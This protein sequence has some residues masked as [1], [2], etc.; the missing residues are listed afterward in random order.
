MNRHQNRRLTATTRARGLRKLRRS[1]LPCDAQLALR[2]GP[3]KGGACCARNRAT[4]AYAPDAAFV[5]VAALR[6]ARLRISRR[7]PDSVERAALS[8]CCEP[9]KRKGR[10][11]T[12]RPAPSGGGRVGVFWGSVGLTYFERLAT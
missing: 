5:T 12:V 1:S 7:P 8:K 9:T 4:S 11:S 2:A 3:P 6:G 10:N